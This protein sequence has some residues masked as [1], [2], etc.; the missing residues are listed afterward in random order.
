M[1]S[2]YRYTFFAI[3]II[4]LLFC[5]CTIQEG[6]NWGD[7]FALYI[8]QSIA[9]IDGNLFDLYAQ[10]KFLE[11]HST[12]NMGPYLYPNGFPLLIVPI[13]KCFSLNYVLLKWYCTVYF[14]LSLPLCWLLFSNKF[15]LKYLA[16]FLVLFIGLNPHYFSFADN[17]LS[18]FPSLFFTYIAL[19]YIPKTKNFWGHILLG[20][21]LFTNYFI[22]EI[23]ITLLPSLLAY[24]TFLFVKEKKI[25]IINFIPYFVF[26]LLLIFSEI[27]LPYGSKNHIGIFFNINVETILHNVFH[28]IKIFTFYP[29]GFYI[30]SMPFHYLAV[31]IIALSPPFLFFI[32]GVCNC[33]KDTLHLLTYFVFS[34]VI[35]ILWPFDQG[36][37]FVFA[38]VPIYMFYVLKGLEYLFLR[39]ALQ[40][41]LLSFLSIYVLY[42]FIFD[43]IYL[44]ENSSVQTNKVITVTTS[45]LYGYIKKSIP[46]DAIIAFDRPR[47]LRLMTGSTTLYASPQKILQTPA[48]HLIV[49]R[50]TPFE[51]SSLELSEQF[52]NKDFIVYKINK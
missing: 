30:A 42:L 4:V 22:R 17:V 44:Y 3:T 28:Y 18:D 8:S 49:N 9:I 40:K 51:L 37:R 32:I 24:Q 36:Y 20:F 14:L 13:I 38:L 11:D 29:T 19:L 7:D 39:N 26:T 27:I 16:L 1:P 45:E 23:N 46:R 48:T 47:I 25:P 31:I 41:K 50:T 5:A 34:M 43:F 10:N 15:Q 52:S 12:M 21:L 6:H 35:L 2:Y 33:F